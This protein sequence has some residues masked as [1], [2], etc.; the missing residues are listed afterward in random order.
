MLVLESSV[1]I[2]LNLETWNEM[3]SKTENASIKSFFY[4]ETFSEIQKLL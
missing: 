1:K 2:I 3:L 4:L